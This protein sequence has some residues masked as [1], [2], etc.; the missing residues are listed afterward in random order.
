MGNSDASHYGNVVSFDELTG[1]VRGFDS[2]FNPANSLFKTPALEA[3]SASAHSVIANYNLF[4]SAYNVAVE[5]RIKVYLP[6]ANLVTRILNF[7]KSSGASEI[8]IAQVATTV[9]KLKGQRAGK[10]LAVPAEGE[11][12]DG[13]KQNS[14]SQVGFDNRLT[15]FDRL[16]T[17]L[18]SI[19]EYAPNESDLNTK[20]LRILWNLME[21]ANKA[22]LNAENGLLTARSTRNTELYAP[23][24]GLT[25]IGL[26]CKLYIKAAYGAKSPQYLQVAKIHFRTYNN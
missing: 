9:R 2:H 4:F 17:Q 25:R 3:K 1:N 5:H 6:L 20:D 11:V 23:V 22:V 8:V 13:P 12:A 14:V 19:P 15:N 10:K 26:G 7:V 21:S 18:E 16:I 24:T